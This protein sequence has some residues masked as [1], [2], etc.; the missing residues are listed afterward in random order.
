MTKLLIILIILIGGCC[1]PCPQE[2]SSSV[3]DAHRL[4]IARLIVE[5]MVARLMDESIEQQKE[6]VELESL[7]ERCLERLDK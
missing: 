3:T 5:S 6:I 1:S 7:L 2:Q 4:V